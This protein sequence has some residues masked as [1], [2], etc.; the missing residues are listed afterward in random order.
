MNN[1]IDVN[2]STVDSRNPAFNPDVSSDQDSVIYCPAC[3]G[4]NPADAVFCV[5][6]QCH[7]ALGEFKYVLEELM[8]SKNWLDR[9]A[10]R[11]A[12]FVSKPHFIILHLLWF[13]VWILANEG[14]LGVIK[15]FDEF[16]YGLLGIILAIEAVLITGF[17]LIS[18]HHQ[19]NYS[20]KRAELDY[21]INIRSYRKLIAME[22]RLATLTLNREDRLDENL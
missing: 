12:L 20:E 4:E 13:V 8:A 17:L 18:Q 21:E 16:P 9:F 11:V 14:Y 1:C 19:Y 2:V 15:H 6:H 3:G 5:N 10:D 7:K 22:K